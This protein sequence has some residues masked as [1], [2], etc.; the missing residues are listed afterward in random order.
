MTT[1]PEWQLY[2]NCAGLPNAVFFTDDEDDTASALRI[3]NGCVVK[4]ECLTYAF[5]TDESMRNG[6]WGGTTE[7]ER[8]KYAKDNNIK[9]P[10][11][12]DRIFRPNTR[13]VW[14]LPEKEDM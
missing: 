12:A 8:I 11:I 13:K 10:K 2:G 3:C 6:V 14:G 9:P 5:E 1:T 4:A 7:Q